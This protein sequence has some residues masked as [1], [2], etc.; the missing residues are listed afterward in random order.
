MA[1]HDAPASGAADV[2]AGVKRFPA[3]LRVPGMLHGAV[4]QAP[5]HGA[6]L[7]SADTAAAAA[8]PGVTVVAD[9][10]FIGVV[11]PTAAAARGALALVAARWAAASWDCPTP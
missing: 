9:G 3:D 5:A 8:L 10:A 1:G 11:A 4:L 7:I 6:A 2:V